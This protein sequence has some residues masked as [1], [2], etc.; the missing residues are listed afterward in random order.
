MLKDKSPEMI[1]SEAASPTKKRDKELQKLGLG[2][3]GTES[4]AS[5]GGLVK[6][7]GVKKLNAIDN[8]QNDVTPDFTETVR[9][10][11]DKRVKGTSLDFDKLKEE[12][13]F[14][15]GQLRYPESQ[16]I[17]DLKVLY[18]DNNE[19]AEQEALE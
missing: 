11:A 19:L 8:G 14:R 2:D 15:D 3:D 9:N 18:V 13:V 6:V 7:D 17:E 4:E 1:I 16:Q 10:L 12:A 5:E